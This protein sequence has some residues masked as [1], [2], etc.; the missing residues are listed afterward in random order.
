MN[1]NP[2]A[3]PESVVDPVEIRSQRPNEVTYAVRLLWIG[4]AISVI[5]EVINLRVIVE[6][7]QAGA[8][9]APAPQMVA[10]VALI[11]V[12]GGA[13]IGLLLWA[14]VISR[15]AAGRNWAR[16]LFLVLL[17]IGMLFLLL[18]LHTT[19]AMYS[20]RPLMGVTAAVNWILQLVPCYL[21]LTPR[22]GAWFKAAQAA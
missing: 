18:N 6:Q 1:R 2:Y 13:A 11:T 20:R 10:N 22:A 14:W 8:S 12:L 17:A 7:I 21:L 5:A 9:R 19:V 4:I 16:W 15:I 3:A